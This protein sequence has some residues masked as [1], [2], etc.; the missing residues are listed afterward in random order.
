M[1]E[2]FSQACLTIPPVVAEGYEPKGQYSTSN[3][4]KLCTCTYPHNDQNIQT[5]SQTDTVGSKTAKTAIVY[6]YDVFGYAPQT[7]QGAVS[8]AKSKRQTT[9]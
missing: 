2:S 3:D 4:V 9:Y 8:T 6:L 7:I 5:D 1:T